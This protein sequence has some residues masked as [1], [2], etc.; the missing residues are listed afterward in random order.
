MVAPDLLAAL[1]DAMPVGAVIWRVEHP[2]DGGRLR[3]VRPN[4]GASL[5]SGVD[6]RAYIGQTM[7]E[8]FPPFAAS[9]LPDQMLQVVFHG[10]SRLDLGLVAYDDDH[11]APGT[12]Q[13]SAYRLGDEHLVVEYVSVTERERLIRDLERQNAELTET[14]EALMSLNEELSHFAHVA[15][16]DLQAPARH[17]RMFGELALGQQT[18][19]DPARAH[20][21]RMVE[22]S[23]RMGGLISDLLTYAGAGRGPL[24]LE[25]V[26][27]LGILDQAAR[28]LE[29]LV[30]ETSAVIHLPDEPLVVWGHG[31]LLGQVMVNLLGNALKFVPE[32]TVPEIHVTAAADDGGVLLTIRDNGIGFD[33]DKKDVIF[34]PFERLSAGRVPGSGIGLAF[35]KRLVERLGGRISAD[36]TPGV[37]A[38]FTLWLPAPPSA[39]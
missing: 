16:H 6:L 32:D 36:A 23:K 14:R 4:R 7:A 29:D 35:C 1:V 39:D 13:V 21:S 2:T 25:A 10:D 38:V 34:K 12:Y 30:S 22:A 15:S 9:G 18:L 5:A 31:T 33:P 26:S 24:A 27:V 37:G 19:V 17:V 20:V 8:A 28:D 11:I 3:M